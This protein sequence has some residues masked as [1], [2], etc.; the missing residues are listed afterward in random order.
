MAFLLAMSFWM[1]SA[2]SAQ[3]KIAEELQ[4]ALDL[5]ER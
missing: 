3:V 4:R 2:S 1:T 5:Y